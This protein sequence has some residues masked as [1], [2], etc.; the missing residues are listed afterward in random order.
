MSGDGWTLKSNGMDFRKCVGMELKP[1]AFG[2]VVSFLCLSFPLPSILLGVLPT[3]RCTYIMMMI[4]G[5]RHI[6][7][8]GAGAG[9]GFSPGQSAGPGAT[10]VPVPQVQVQVHVHVQVQVQVCYM[11]IISQA[12]KPR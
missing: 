1:L 6:M 5:A 2:S 7:M 3:E 8:I 10:A 9:G 11:Q 4:H 12:N